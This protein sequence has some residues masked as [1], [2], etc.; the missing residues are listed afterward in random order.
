MSGPY[1]GAEVSDTFLHRW[2]YGGTHE[3]K[4]PPQQ[5]GGARPQ[6]TIEIRRGRFVRRYHTGPEWSGP[7]FGDIAGGVPGLWYAD[8]TP[9]EDWIELGGLMDHRCE[10][11]FQNNGVTAASITIDNTVMQEVAG[12]VG[13][14][15]QLMHGWFTPLRGYD[16]AG[17]PK[18]GLD[19]SP[20]FQKL[21][22]A[23]IRLRT[24]YG[25]AL[26]T[27]FLGLIDDIETGS[28]PETAA[29]TARDMGGPM[30]VD[31]HFF[32]WAKEP[33]ITDP[34]IFMPRAMAEHREMRG[35]G[36]AAS[37]TKPGYPARGVVQKG[38]HNAWLSQP[39]DTSEVTEWVEIHVPA[40]HYRAIYINASFD[41]ELF[42]SV[43]AKPRGTKHKLLSRWLPNSGEAGAV[44]L[45]EDMLD[46]KGYV[47]SPDGGPS[48]P[49][50]WVKF[51]GDLVPG[52]NGGIPYIAHRARATPGR[53]M[54]IPLGGELW[55]GADSVI[56]V[57][58]RHLGAIDR[59]YHAG[60]LRLQAEARLPTKEAKDARYVL[61]D[62]V[63]EIIEC[64]LRWAG[65]KTWEIETAGVDLKEKYVVDKSKAFMD[66]VNEIKEMLGYTFF[67]GEPRNDADDQDLG[68]PIFRETR[69]L[70]PN[71]PRTEQITDADMLT[72]GRY[73]L[74][75]QDERY[76]IRARGK[77]LSAKKGGKWLSADKVNRAMFVYRPPWHDQMA[78]IIK[79]LTHFDAKYETIAD[80][81]QAALLIA[82][83]IAL[84]KYT[85][86]IAI[87]GTPHIGVDTSVSLLDGTVGVN[88]RFYISNRVQTFTGGEQAK[89]VT[90][91]G[92]GLADT[93]DVLAVAADYKHF[94]ATTDRNDPR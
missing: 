69:I 59:K 18:L 26:E 83:Q 11:S 31:Q 8:W 94:I 90:E 54:R 52:D 66:V 13:S 80:C 17:R 67:M 42:I 88:S 10:Q 65:F 16:P 19:H 77:E 85:G 41:H 78:G 21:P 60:V 50:G 51:D 20:F 36:A 55:L 40:G 61:I 7:I 56:R 79:H 15:H 87:P 82:L 86:T 35:G 4:S 72:Q 53:G 23:Q 24:G 81:Q 33:K 63:T 92:G 38:A 49:F 70:N 44:L 5:V 74:S 71:Q 37:S 91:L 34:V 76:I 84:G 30:L 27:E 3:S 75:N 9:E 47:D 39:H 22:N 46:V 14:F 57:G 93:P 28:G 48:K 6:S 12:V 68:Y 32:G 25:D 2:R 29:I 64:V 1:V 62:D 45:D 58:I 89:Y 73:K 43:M